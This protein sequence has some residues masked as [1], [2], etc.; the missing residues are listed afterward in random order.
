MEDRDGAKDILSEILSDGS[1]VQQ[2]EARK[3]MESIA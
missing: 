2:K 1:D 3:L